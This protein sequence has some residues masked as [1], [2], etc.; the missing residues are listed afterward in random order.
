MDGRARRA[1]RGG[2]QL[3]LQRLAA[4]LPRR[5]PPRVFGPRRPEEVDGG[6]RAIRARIRS[7]PLAVVQP[8]RETTRLCGE[9]RRPMG[10]GGRRTGSWLLSAAS[11]SRHTGS[12]SSTCRVERTFSW[13]KGPTPCRPGPRT[14]RN[15]P[16]TAG[17]KRG[18][19]F[20]SPAAPGWTRNLRKRE[21]RFRSTPPTRPAGSTRPTPAAGRRNPKDGRR[22]GHR[23]VRRGW[24]PG[25]RRISPEA[26][27]G[28]V[29][30]WWRG[31]AGKRWFS[32]TGGSG[33]SMTPFMERFS[34]RTAN[35]S[36][37]WRAT[38]GSSDGVAGP[39]YDLIG[40]LI[41]SPDGDHVA[42]VAKKGPKQ[43]VVVDGSAIAS[44]AALPA[45]CACHA[46]TILPAKAFPKEEG[47]I[48]IHCTPANPKIADEPVA[49]NIIV[50]RV[51]FSDARGGMPGV[52][53]RQVGAVRSASNEH[54][55]HVQ[56]QGRDETAACRSLN[57]L[58][59]AFPPSRMAWA[60]RHHV[61]ARAGAA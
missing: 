37:M 1:L 39:E 42:Y 56:R 18:G 6:R 50:R 60:K 40:T 16:S 31:A 45:R 24:A 17:R 29:W 41:F 38:A 43:L 25:G 32:S 8:G 59:L 36:P 51:T 13:S 46:V 34:A 4:L 15:R 22:P 2:V 47:R 61:A 21:S 9:D 28:G 11:T 27:T 20:G 23:F 30:R 35:A 53:R 26:G 5:Q 3:R 10:R 52:R 44:S 57:V 58:S 7:Y 49:T 33:R 54:R 12:G 48:H 19:R 14:V 55:V